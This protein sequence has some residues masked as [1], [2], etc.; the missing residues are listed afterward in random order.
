MPTTPGQKFR[1]AL[2]A[3]KPLQIA[4]TINAYCA[5][6]AKSIGFKALY[7]SGAGVANCSYGLPDLGMTTLDNVLEDTSRITSAVDLPLLVDIDTGWGNALMIERTIKSM[8][9][10]GAAAVH[11]EDQVFA[12]RCGHHSGK[13]LVSKEE[14]CG[15]I[16]AAVDARSDLEFVIMARTDAF[17]IEGIDLTI[18]RTLAYKEAGADM[19]FAEAVDTLEHYK[20]LKDAVG[21][22]LLAN[23][24]EFG[25]TPLFTT[26]ELAKAGVD[27]ALYPL[28]ASR[29]MNQAAQKVYQDIRQNGTQK[30]SIDSMQTRDEL[31]RIL[32]YDDYEQKVKTGL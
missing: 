9:R 27:M 17:S 24:T 2:H 6:M 3:E 32:H 5:L 15:R 20:I 16:K 29:A 31:Y 11:I 23:L 12:K 14:M 7:L 8:I 25:R 10:A 18:D 30:K 4:G 21:I 1:K 26:E 22:P 19:L 28:S 13:V